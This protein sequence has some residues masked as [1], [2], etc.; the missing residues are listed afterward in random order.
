MTHADPSGVG[1]AGA[2]GTFMQIDALFDVHG[3]RFGPDALLMFGFESDEPARVRS[4][5]AAMGAGEDMLPVFDMDA[6][7]AAEAA[8]HETLGAVITRVLTTSTSTR[9]EA[10]VSS[11]RTKLAPS[12]VCFVSGLCAEEIEEVAVMFSEMR[13]PGG[14]AL[15]A[16]VPRNVE[17][18]VGALLTEV[19]E[20]YYANMINNNAATAFSRPSGDEL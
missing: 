14:V 13:L 3:G 12:R 11:R 17:K 18:A 9:R 20:D 8:L 2:K 19:R 7:D 1:A 6:M 5:L 15:A 4:A 10:D 16:A